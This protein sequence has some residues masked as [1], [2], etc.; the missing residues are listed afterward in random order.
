MASSLQMTQKPLLCNGIS[1]TELLNIT[2]KKKKTFGE[3]LFI[4]HAFVILR[5]C[6][7]HLQ[8]TI[9]SQIGK[10]FVKVENI[11]GLDFP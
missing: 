10:G 9:A 7:Y 5:R 4:K 8:V 1:I 11:L 2:I 6:E 3:V